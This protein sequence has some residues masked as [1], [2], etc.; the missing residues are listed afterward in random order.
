MRNSIGIVEIPAVSK[1][2]KMFAYKKGINFSQILREK[3]MLTI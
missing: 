2:M 1:M 3:I